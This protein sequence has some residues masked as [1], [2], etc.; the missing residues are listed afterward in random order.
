VSAA[1]RIEPPRFAMTGAGVVFS[2]PFEFYDDVK[3]YSLDAPEY[4]A[5]GGLRQ[6]AV[7]AQPAS[8][9]IVASELRS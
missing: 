6:A 5:R 4:I 8:P 1:I 9:Y 7:Q 2:V 3:A